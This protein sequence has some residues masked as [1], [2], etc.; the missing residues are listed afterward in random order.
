MIN[1]N[2]HTFAVLL[3]YGLLGGL[4]NWALYH[5]DVAIM[6]YLSGEFLATCKSSG[7]IIAIALGYMNA[8]TVDLESPVSFSSMFAAGFAIDKALNKKPDDIR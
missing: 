5:R 1:N 2:V 6:K 8:G 3:T 7:G 4:L